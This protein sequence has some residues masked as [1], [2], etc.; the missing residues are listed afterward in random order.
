MR[1]SSSS[2]R[3]AFTLI[4]LLVVIAIIAILIGLL[5]PAVQK[6]REAA[7]RM[8]CANNLKQLTLALHNYH[9]ANSVLPPTQGTSHTALASIGP[10][11]TGGPI[12]SWQF[13][14]L[15]YIEQGALHQLGSTYL[16]SQTALG[17]PTAAYG[18]ANSFMAQSPKTF[19]CPSDA[20][21]GRSP[22][23]SGTV[24]GAPSLYG[25]NSYGV[26]SGTGSI[27]NQGDAEKMDG[28]FFLKS[29]VQIGQIADGTSN[30]LAMGERTFND[31]GLRS[32]GI[33][34]STL[35]AHSSLWRNGWVPPLSNIRV[36]LD[37]INY[38]M[39]AG[40]TGAAL[41]L[42][43]LKRLLGY[44]SDHTGGANFSFCDGSVRFLR[45]GFSQL[46]LQQLSTRAGGEV[47]TNLD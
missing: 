17:W 31:P 11:W 40:L 36:P 20:F 1:R 6:V 29:K 12:P 9:D 21:V 38:K 39:P 45:D 26:N 35:V 18:D 25:L 44:S 8:T 28:P 42:G 2:R 30:T 43:F 10:A 15:P 5:L 16:T 7:A 23:Q 33:A 32:S 34:E 19:R 37:Q 46:T 13:A 14:I 47:I 4:E 27:W 24:N 22:A 3:S 41:N